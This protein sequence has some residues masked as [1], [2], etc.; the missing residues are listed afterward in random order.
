MVIETSYKVSSSIN[1]MI[2]NVDLANLYAEQ[3]RC[4]IN[5]MMTYG[6][7]GCTTK[8]CVVFQPYL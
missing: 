4:D 7:S 5:I 2:G 6:C 3:A 8:P 1:I